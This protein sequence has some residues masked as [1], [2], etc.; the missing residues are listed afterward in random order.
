MAEYGFDKNLLWK[1]DKALAP[2][3]KKEFS[4]ELKV[5]K[6]QHTKDNKIPKRIE[7]YDID[8]HRG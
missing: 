2:N 5:F 6:R 7:D 1:Y 4:K 8:I 3:N